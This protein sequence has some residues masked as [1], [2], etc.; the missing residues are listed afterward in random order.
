MMYRIEYGVSV[1]TKVWPVRGAFYQSWEVSL[2]Y[3]EQTDTVHFLD[4][5]EQEIMNT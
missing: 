2:T 3:G 1:G 5:S 4:Y